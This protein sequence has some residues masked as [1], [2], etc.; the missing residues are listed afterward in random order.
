MALRI[1]QPQAASYPA[2]MPEEE[3]PV[4]APAEEIPELPV[5]EEPM[6]MEPGSVVEWL[7][8]AIDIC[9]SYDCPEE[10]A[11]ALEQALA[12]LI[13]P[14]AVEA[15]ESVPEPVITPEA[16]VDS[17]EPEDEEAL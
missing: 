7:Q 8:E 11:Y 2:V 14:S 9:K 3:L 10:L 4:E 16:P 12:L 1:G 5:M 13:G 6:P 15:T 17:E